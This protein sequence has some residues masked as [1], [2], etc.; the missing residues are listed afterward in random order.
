MKITH[1]KEW[2]FQSMPYFFTKSLSLPCTNEGQ[3]CTCLVCTTPCPAHAAN[4]SLR[5][6]HSH[7]RAGDNEY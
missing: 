4:F 5:K 3:V 1:Y 7:Q 2:W 6:S